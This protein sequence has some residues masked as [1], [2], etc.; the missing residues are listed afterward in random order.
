MRLALHMCWYIYSFIL[1]TTPSGKYSARSN[2][3]ESVCE[4]TQRVAGDWKAKDR[5]PLTVAPYR[6]E[7]LASNC[8]IMMEPLLDKMD[9]LNDVVERIG[10]YLVEKNELQAPTNNRQVSPV[11]L[12]KTLSYY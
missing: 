8:R 11:C 4:L 1:S 2:A 12:L 6:D 10:S 3:G 9:V 7:A 5:V